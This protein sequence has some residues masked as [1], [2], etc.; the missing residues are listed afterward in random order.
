VLTRVLVGGENA[1]PGFLDEVQ[2][3]HHQLSLLGETFDAPLDGESHEPGDNGVEQDQDRNR[4]NNLFHALAP[5]NNARVVGVSA[6]NPKRP[7][8]LS[9]G[10]H[11]AWSTSGRARSSSTTPNADTVSGVPILPEALSIASAQWVALIFRQRDRVGV[12]PEEASILRL[13][14]I[15]AH[16]IPRCSVRA[17]GV[18]SLG[19][20]RN[21]GIFDRLPF[22]ALTSAL[23]PRAW[24]KRIASSA[25]TAALPLITRSA[26]TA[27]GSG[28]LCICLIIE[29]SDV[30]LSYKLSKRM[31]VDPMKRPF[32][33]RTHWI[34]WLT[35]VVIAIA[36]LLSFEQ[37]AITRYF[38]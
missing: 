11:Y 4:G 28:G 1:L 2:L 23:V 24:P 25:D 31:L 19:G 20:G 34:V 15:C 27:P 33:P 36:P 12:C 22:D 21:L 7:V 14:A 3:R 17:I 16:N 6:R 32:R 13:A 5:S 9:G 38:K 10:P 35:I 29:F 8:G 30:F 37:G 26:R 18:L